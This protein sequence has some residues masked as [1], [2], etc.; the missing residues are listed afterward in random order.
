[1]VHID[2]RLDSVRDLKS[3]SGFLNLG[4]YASPTL[5]GGK[6]GYS[7]LVSEDLSIFADALGGYSFTLGRPDIAAHAGLRY[8]W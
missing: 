7:H 4:L 8:K 2:E 6:L 5:V 1:M 3:G